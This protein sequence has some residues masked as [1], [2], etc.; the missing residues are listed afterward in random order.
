MRLAVRREAFS[1]PDW[2]FEIKYEGF[3]SLA[4][5]PAARPS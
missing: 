4:A 2:I 5:S 1:H 3:R